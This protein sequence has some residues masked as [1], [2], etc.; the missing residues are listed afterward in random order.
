MLE[1]QLEQT[2]KLLTDIL[3]ALQGGAAL[4]SAAPSVAPQAEESS[5]DTQGETPTKEDVRD[6]LMTYNDQHGREATIALMTP[7]LPEGAKPI[8][9]DIPETCYA[10]VIAACNAQLK[11]A[12]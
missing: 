10:D 4:Q 2:N 8:L 3:T 6:A 9:S 11:D 7:F 1:Q 5:A 12:A